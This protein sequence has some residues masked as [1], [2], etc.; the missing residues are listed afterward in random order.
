MHGTTTGNAP[1]SAARPR[2]RRPRHRNGTRFGYTLSFT[3]GGL[4]GELI[5]NTHEDGTLREIFIY[6][7]KHGSTLAG[8]LDNLAAAVSIGLRNGV[9]LERY[10]DEFAGVGFSPAGMTDDPD[11]RRASSVMDYVMRRLARDFLRQPVIVHDA[12]VG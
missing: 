7:G 5:A 6:V 3:V 12:T 9:P 4:E 1:T 2:A 8:L 11:V 10:V